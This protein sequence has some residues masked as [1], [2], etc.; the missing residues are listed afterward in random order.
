MSG[1]QKWL[2]IGITAAFSLTVTVAML[3]SRN[4]LSQQSF[5][6]TARIVCDAFFVPAV[7]I[8]GIGL[9][10]AISETGFFDMVSYG[11]KSLI[12]L[13]TPYDKRV[14]RGGYYEY[15]VDMEEKRKGSPK[16]YPCILWV[17]LADLVVSL[18]FFALYYAA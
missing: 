14:G 5:V 7:F 12:R 13:F 8:G 2:I 17:A 18:V 16:I 11:F 15:K 4:V 6:E 10:M 9:L 3:A 1:K